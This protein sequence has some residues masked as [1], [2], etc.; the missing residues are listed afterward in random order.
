M[1]S[2]KTILDSVQVSKKISE[3]ADTILADFPGDS[4]RDVA[5]LGIQSKGIPLASRIAEALE[6]KSGF[7][8]PLG[9]IDISMFRD[10]I[11]AGKSFQS[12]KETCIPFDIEEGALI[13]VDDV[14]HTGRT[15][16][17]ALDAVTNYGRPSLIRLA[18]LIDRG[19]REFPISPDYAGERRI[20]GKDAKILVKWKETDGEDLAIL[21]EDTRIS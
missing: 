17:A 5:I 18:V 9:S 1:S 21:I 13:L 10:D 6:K 3:I 20:V 12:I 14:L 19:G 15:I 16:R 8:P 4:I 2:S 7:A 11:G